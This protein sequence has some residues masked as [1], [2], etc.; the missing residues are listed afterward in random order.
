MAALQGGTILV[1][2]VLASDQS[3]WLLDNLVPPAWRPHLPAVYEAIL[4]LGRGA[5]RVLGPELAI[6]VDSS[7]CITAVGHKL[8]RLIGVVA[9]GAVRCAPAAGATLA[10]VAAAALAAPRLS[11]AAGLGR[12]RRL[13]L[14]V[15]LLT[16]PPSL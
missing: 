12:R 3:E 1:D 2:G 15:C 6:A 4:V 5:Y 14:F 13:P 9:R 16:R 10:A 8:G 11:S 7:L